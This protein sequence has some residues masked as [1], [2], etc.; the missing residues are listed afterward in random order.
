MLSLNGWPLWL[1]DLRP[2]CQEVHGPSSVFG[3]RKEGPTSS[4][5][6]ANNSTCGENG[7]YRV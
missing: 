1:W 3:G 5:M 2:Q 7:P 6:Q 4:I